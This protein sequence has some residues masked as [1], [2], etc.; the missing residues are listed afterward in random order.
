MA[1]YPDADFAAPHVRLADEAVRLGPASAVESYLSVERV[2]AAAVDSGAQA[3]HPGYGFL[4]ESAAFACACIERGVVFVGPSP[5]AIEALGDKVSAKL[6]AQGAS[7]PVL[8]GLQRPDLAD[9]EILAFAGPRTRRWPP[10]PA[11]GP[12]QHPRRPRPRPVG[13]RQRPAGTPTQARLS[14]V[15]R[16][17][18]LRRCRA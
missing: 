3:I 18:G 5:E 15:S 4:S 2:L 16:K 9:E 1:V 12:P 7:V 8:P 10:P 11:E 17:L 13:L 6:L 14:H